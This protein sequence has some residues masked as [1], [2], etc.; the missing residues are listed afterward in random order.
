MTVERFRR[1]AVPDRP[2][3][4]IASHALSRGGPHVR[5]IQVQAPVAVVVEPSRAH[6]R[7]DVLHALLFGDVPKASV[8]VLVEIIPAKVVGDVELGPAVLVVVAPCGGKAV[9]VIVLAESRLR[10]DVDEGAAPVALQ[11]VAEQE[12]RRPVLRVVIGSG[13]AVLILALEVQIRAQVQVQLAVPIIVGGGH[14]CERALGLL[15]EPERVLA[16]TKSARAIVE[17]QQRPGGCEHDQV[18]EPQ[19]PQVQEQRLGGVVQHPD[20]RF[21][22]DV[23]PDPVRPPAVEPVGQAARLAHVQ[24]VPAVSVDIA[25][26]DTLVAVDSDAGGRIEPR[27]PV[28]NPLGELIAKRVEV[29][30]EFRR[31]VGEQGPRRLRDGFGD[32]FESGEPVARPSHAPLADAILEAACGFRGDLESHNVV[33]E[34]VKSGSPHLA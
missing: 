2:E 26:R 4:R 22:G 29:A 7:A 3:L 25:D 21:I 16:E 6:A 28:G 23:G 9:A 13:I 19:V 12:V 14:A 20:A 27:A 30:E 5:D 32:R 18:L 8:R 34:G 15:A 11:L 24:L 10:R 17:E 1:G 33:G 31:D